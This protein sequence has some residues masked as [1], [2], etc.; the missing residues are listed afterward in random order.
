M[1]REGVAVRESER[2]TGENSREREARVMAEEKKGVVKFQH[3]CL[4]M[5]TNS[6]PR[7]TPCTPGTAKS[8]CASGEDSTPFAR[9]LV[10]SLL[11]P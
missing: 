7:N 10:N 2:G 1:E 3:T 8:L 9:L 6:E 5:V 4:V 11:P